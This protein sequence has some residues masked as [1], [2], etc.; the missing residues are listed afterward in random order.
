M[1]NLTVLHGCQTVQ[2]INGFSTLVDERDVAPLRAYRLLMTVS[3]GTPTYVQTRSGKRYEHGAVK[4][5]YL[6]R[7]LVGA[8]AGMH[9]DHRNGDRRDNR[10]ENLRVCTHAENHRNRR[11]IVSKT[12]FKGVQ[13]YKTS[14]TKPWVA[15]IVVKR[16]KIHIGCFAT[17]VEAAR[18]YDAKARELF[19]EFAATN[20]EL[21]GPEAFALRAVTD[22]PA[23]QTNPP[24]PA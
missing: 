17:A 3:R 14:P 8:P 15:S 21:L 7:F 13:P 16:H 6:H 4:R 10:R 19:G 5:D 2:T 11:A 24:V 12:G 23:D 9:V 1:S 18:A 20:E 22:D